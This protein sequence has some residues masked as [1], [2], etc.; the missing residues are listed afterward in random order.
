M[1][2]KILK[3]LP[4]LLIAILVGITSVYAGSLTPPGAP[5]KTMKSLSDLYELIDTGANTPSTDFATP[6]TVSST[7]HSLGD[8]YDLLKSQLDILTTDKIAKDEEVF[9]RT[10]TLYGDTD[11]SKVLDTATYPGTATVGT[12]APTFASADQTTYS[13]EA[14]AIDPAQPAVTLETICGYHTGDGCSW[15]GSACTGGTKTPP[16]GYMTWYAA[17]ASCSETTDE[18]STDWRLPNA[19]ELFS[20]YQDNNNAGLPPDGFVD[21]YYWSETTRSSNSDSAY[22]FSMFNGNM[23]N[24]DKSFPSILVHCAH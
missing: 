19:K 13:C 10:G 16:G 12:P 23:S 21:D 6:T 20:H 14:L 24:G 4:Y 7:M 17:T 1:K 22:F 15:S 9:G 18:G 8:T 5:A 2:N 3:T 11:P